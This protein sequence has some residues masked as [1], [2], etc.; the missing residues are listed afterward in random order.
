[1]V[2]AMKLHVIVFKNDFHCVRL[3]I[4]TKDKDKLLEACW[5]EEEVRRVKWRG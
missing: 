5:V 4:E 3:A 2:D 1:M